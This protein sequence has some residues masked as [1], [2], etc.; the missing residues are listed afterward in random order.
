MA[1]R[2]RG[3]PSR[4]RKV[5]RQ[6]RQWGGVASNAVTSFLAKLIAELVWRRFGPN[7]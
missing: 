4:R 2:K 5:P 6:L 3:R 1:S 7:P